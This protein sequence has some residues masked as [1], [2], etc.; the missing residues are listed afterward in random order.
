MFEIAEI[1]TVLLSLGGMFLLGLL[2]DIAGRHTP[3]PRVTLLLLA[4]ILIG[5]YGLALLPEVFLER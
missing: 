2:A 5:P 4:G 1:P 3:L